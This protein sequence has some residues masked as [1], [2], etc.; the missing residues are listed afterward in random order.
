[1]TKR[2]RTLLAAQAKVKE[3]G[4]Q[5]DPSEVQVLKRIEDVICL[6]VAGRLALQGFPMPVPSLRQDELFR[7]ST[8][9]IQA[10]FYDEFVNIDPDTRQAI[11]RI[12]MD[13]EVATVPLPF[14]VRHMEETE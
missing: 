14:T 12:V 6:P 3:M 13:T 8:G 9:P 1:M 10:S 5:V 2:P 11:E 7:A 4:L